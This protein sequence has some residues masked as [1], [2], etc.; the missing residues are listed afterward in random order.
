MDTSSIC[1]KGIV[2]KIS[3]NRLFV[4]I[5]RHTACSGCH[6]KGACSAFNKRDEVIP[7]SVA[8]PNLFKVG[9]IVQLSIKRS[10]GA[11]AV[12]IAYLCPFLVLITGL[13]LTYYF[14]KNELLSVGVAFGATVLYYL[15]IKKID[16]RLQ[17]QFSF[18]VSKIHE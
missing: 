4:E 15:F 11:K 5:E 16:S 9:E 7:I 1:H 12:V 2:K 10:L 13:F 3:G 6:A 17:K 18:F 14:T 8:E